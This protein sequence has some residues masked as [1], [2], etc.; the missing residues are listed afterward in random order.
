MDV[1]QLKQVVLIT[2]L[3]VIVQP[4]AKV[5]LSIALTPLMILVILLL[6]QK[7]AVVMVQ[8]LEYAQL[9]NHQDAL[10]AIA[11]CATTY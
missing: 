10:F 5:P 4:H 3:Q 9:Q 11:R 8:Q 1:W 2:P 6:L 7:L